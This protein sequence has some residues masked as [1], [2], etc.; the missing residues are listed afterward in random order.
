MHDVSQQTIHREPLLLRVVHNHK[1]F[2]L[3]VRQGG[4]VPAV[5]G[6]KSTCFAQISGEALLPI[7]AIGVKLIACYR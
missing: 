2:Q 1:P 3:V 7:R 4:E 5:S 6:A